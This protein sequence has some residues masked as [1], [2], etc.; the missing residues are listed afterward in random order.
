M[1]A[2]FQLNNFFDKYLDIMTAYC[3]RCL[4]PGGKCIH[5]T[6]EVSLCKYA[7]GTCGV[8]LER[9]Y[10]GNYCLNHRCTECGGERMSGYRFC[11]DHKCSVKDCDLKAKTVHKQTYEG[12]IL[13]QYC[14]V[15]S[16]SKKPS[17]DVS[18][19]I[20]PREKGSLYCSYH[21]CSVCRQFHDCRL[22]TCLFCGLNNCSC[23]KNYCKVCSAVILN[24]NVCKSHRCC[25]L[26]CDNGQIGNSELCII[27]K[28]TQCDYAIDGC[29]VHRFHNLLFLARYLSVLPKDISKIIYA[30]SN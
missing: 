30:Y 24:G 26:H 18:Y 9:Y 20:E 16:R 14:L 13:L 19:C 4:S 15:H 21:K 29:D 28:C 25:R 1:I 8:Q 22:H 10:L 12:E 11:K 27:H 6:I 2:N 7:R 5:S 3:Y 23:I 17:C